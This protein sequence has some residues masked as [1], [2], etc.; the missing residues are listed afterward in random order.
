[1][2]KS[3]FTKPNNL[4]DVRGVTLEERAKLVLGTLGRTPQEV[5]KAYRKIAG[6]YHPDVPGGDELKFQVISE[7][8]TLLAG[9]ALPGKP[10]LADDDLLLR[11]TGRHVAPLIDK[12]K[13]WK[14][15]ERWRR[16]QFY[17]SSVW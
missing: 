9:G 7:A 10:L 4:D 17:D 15:Y 16:A 11:V 13:E 3:I 12:Q 8:Y 14:R 1:M 2:T 6:K 5:K